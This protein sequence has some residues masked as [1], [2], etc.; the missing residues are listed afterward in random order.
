MVENGPDSSIS[1]PV[2]VSKLDSDPLFDYHGQIEKVNE[3][4]EKR[5]EEC[6]VK[7]VKMVFDKF[8][9]ITVPMQ[10]AVNKADLKGRAEDVGGEKALELG[11]ESGLL[12]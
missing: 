9:K 4:L 10:F 12:E 6:F 1:K 8:R 3:R 11:D 7:D 2:D 5:D